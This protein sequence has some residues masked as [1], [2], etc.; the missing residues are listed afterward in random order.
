MDYIDLYVVHMDQTR[1]E[2]NGVYRHG[3]YGKISPKSLHPMY[4][5]KVFAMKNGQR[6]DK[7]CWT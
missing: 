5:V 3:R 6:T 7:S 4:N 2:V 1:S